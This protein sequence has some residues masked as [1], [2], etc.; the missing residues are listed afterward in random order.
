MNF[1]DTVKAHTPWELR[2]VVREINRRIRWV[3]NNRRPVGE[4]FQEVYQQAMWGG[5]KGEFYSGPGSDSDAATHYAAG[6]AEFIASRKIRSVV[7]LGCG[8][9][10]VAKTFLGDNDVDY[11]GVDIVEP[12]VRQNI[13]KHGGSRIGF[14]CLNIIRD[15]LPD[16]ELCLIREVLQHLSNAEILRVLPKIKQ[17]RYVVYSDYQPGPLA[18]CVPNRDIGHGID[19]RIWKDF[20]TVPRSASVP[21]TDEAAVR[22]CVP[23]CLASP[24]R[25]YPHVS[26]MALICYGPDLLWP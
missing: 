17:Y 4:V 7:D 1:I 10:R 23:P 9:F 22:G 20:G 13:A 14:A 24:G 25:A 16:G 6:I 21:S 19:I 11:M 15:P 2:R 3:R 5:E 18:P 12:L 26:A 8:D